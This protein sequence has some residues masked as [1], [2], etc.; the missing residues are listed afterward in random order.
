MLLP[1]FV[2]LLASL[3]PS[4]GAVTVVFLM[5]R[6][7]Q[8]HIDAERELRREF[9]G[10]YHQVLQTNHALIEETNKLLGRVCVLLE[11]HN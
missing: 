8:K 4:A 9:V 6:G 3:G 1:E 2:E 11:R 10:K 5:L 7:F